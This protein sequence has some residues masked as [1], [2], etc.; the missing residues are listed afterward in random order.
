MDA[1]AVAQITRAPPR[2][3]TASYT[4]ASPGTRDVMKHDLSLRRSR[5][6]PY[7]ASISGKWDGSSLTAASNASRALSSSPSRSRMAR[8]RRI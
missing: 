7:S 2:H 6:A 1:S 3:T 5:K 8:A 4:A